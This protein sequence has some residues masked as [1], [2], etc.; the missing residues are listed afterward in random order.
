MKRFFSCDRGAAAVEAAII[1]PVLLSI[2]LGAAETGNLVNET[3]KMKTGL[4]SGARMLARAPAPAPASVETEA[5]NLAVTGSIDGSLPARLPGWRTSQV[6]VSYRFVD[7]SGA[8]YTGGDQIRVVRL[9]S[10]RPYSGCA[11]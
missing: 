7:N 11:C 6:T 10:S 4:A 9:D 5:L 2:G 8:L 1:V 3:H